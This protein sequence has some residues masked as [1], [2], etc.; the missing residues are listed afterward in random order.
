MDTLNV[1]RRNV[2][3]AVPGYKIYVRRR[4]RARGNIKTARSVH[5]ACLFPPCRSRRISAL[6][7]TYLWT[8][9][10]TSRCRPT[11]RYI[12]LL[13]NLSREFYRY[14][15]T[16]LKPQLSCCVSLVWRQISR[17][18]V[19]DIFKGNF[20]KR[21]FKVCPLCMYVCLFVCFPITQETLQLLRWNF[22]ATCSACYSHVS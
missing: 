13:S 9:R 21:Y 19:L 7:T 14:L 4:M 16:T 11:A 17:I 10:L 8:I 1:E 5:R 6:C 18:Q 22:F 12:P 20:K 15:R 2:I 3:R